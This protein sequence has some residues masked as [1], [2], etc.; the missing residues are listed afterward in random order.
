MKS[1]NERESTIVNANWIAFTFALSVFS[2]VNAIL[3][4]FY[5]LPE[6]E[7]LIL[8]INS[9]ISMVLMVDFLYSAI[10]YRANRNFLID[11]YGW[12]AFIGSL[13]LPG[14]AIFRI[15]RSA[16]VI[17]KLRRTELSEASRLVLKQRGR[18][19]FLSTLLLAI[20]GLELT[21]LLILS[22]ENGA[23]YAEITTAS[24]ALWWGYVTMSTVGYGDLVP[25]TTDGRVIGLITMT[26]GVVLFSVTTSF[27]TDWFRRERTPMLPQ[28]DEESD[29]AADDPR[30]RLKA[31]K[32][33]MA[34]QEQA[35]KNYIARLQDQ[36]DDLEKLIT[37]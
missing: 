18:S 21:G 19:T 5:E 17:R 11:W 16:F 3:L 9:A 14:I 29:E 32:R 34:E 6:A 12:M 1:D 24:D 20:V 33:L 10:K 23:P 28:L 30:R 4:L 37:S 26:V 36:I 27:M 8:I 2:V 35:H 7:S 13:P 15:I 22:A 25:V 31:I